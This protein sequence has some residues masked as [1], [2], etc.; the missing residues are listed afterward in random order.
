MYFPPPHLVRLHPVTGKVIWH[1]ER[2]GVLKATAKDSEKRRI[3]RLAA[4]SSGSLFS[5]LPH[6]QRVK[7]EQLFWRYCENW[8][9]DLPT[10]RR[11]L[12]IGV[13]RRYAVKPHPPGWRRRMHWFYGQ[14]MGKAVSPSERQRRKKAAEKD[15]DRILPIRQLPIG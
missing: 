2:I 3:A 8:K 4:D 1:P 9:H 11:N 13:A 15:K 12:L 10:W 5:D 14:R 7:A 6:E